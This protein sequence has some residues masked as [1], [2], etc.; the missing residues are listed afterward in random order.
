LEGVCG[1]R[2]DLSTEEKVALMKKKL[3]TRI[4]VSATAGG[5]RDPEK[6]KVRAPG[7]GARIS[8]LDL[9]ARVSRTSVNVLGCC[10]SY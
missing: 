10:G 9:A 3:A 1:D 4:V 5:V 8:F 2:P 7:L 6:L